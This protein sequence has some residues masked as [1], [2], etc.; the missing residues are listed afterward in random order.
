[1]GFLS[2]ESFPP[3]T[4]SWIFMD[5]TKATQVVQGKG[6][7]FRVQVKGSSLLAKRAR[8]FRTQ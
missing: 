2:G 8:A 4:I 3:P 6:L 5:P 7:R 1:M